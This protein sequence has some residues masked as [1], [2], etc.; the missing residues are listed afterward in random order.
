[1]IYLDRNATTRPTRAQKEAR[2]LTAKYAEY[3]NKAKGIFLQE[4]T[5]LTKGGNCQD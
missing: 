4:R 5:K 1:M 2:I 3:T